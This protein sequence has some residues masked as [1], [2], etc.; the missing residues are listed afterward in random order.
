MT[1]PDGVSGSLGTEPDARVFGLLRALCDV[2]LVG[3]ST[4]RREAYRPVTVDPRWAPFRTAAGLGEEPPL[5]AVVS[6]VTTLIST[7]IGGPISDRTGRRKPA[8]IV[9]GPLL[10][11]GVLV[12]AGVLK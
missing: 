5:L 11:W 9:A 8:A 12:W 1:G 3:G 7:F 2:V 10:V 4:A 6:M